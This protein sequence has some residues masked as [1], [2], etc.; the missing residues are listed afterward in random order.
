[1]NDK[2]YL[3]LK[4]ELFHYSSSFAY[5]CENN[6]EGWHINN[7]TIEFSCYSKSHKTDPVATI[8]SYRKNNDVIITINDGKAGLIV[9]SEYRTESHILL[10]NKIFEFLRK[11]KQDFTIE[12]V[13][14]HGPDWNEVKLNFP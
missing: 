6:S 10:E 5:E 9:S 3:E 13:F 11:Y 1:M 2:S 8:D 7:Y 4:K 12:A 14:S